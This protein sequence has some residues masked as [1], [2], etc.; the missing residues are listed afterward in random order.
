LDNFEWQEG[1][2]ERFGLHYVDFED[3]DRPRTPKASAKFY[4]SII[5]DNGFP[6]SA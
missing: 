3:P 2:S 5:Q 4:T 1:Y 6:D